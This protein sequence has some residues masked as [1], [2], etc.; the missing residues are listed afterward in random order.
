MSHESSGKSDD[1][2][3][4]S[5]IFDALGERFD[6][7]V[8]APEDRTFVS[9]PATNFLTSYALDLPWF[10]FVWMNPPPFGKRGSKDPWLDKFF[11]HGNG[12][13]LTPDR[14]GS[15]WWQSAFRRA[16]AVL[17]CCGKPKFVRPDGSIGK[18]PGNNVCLWASG[19][20]AVEALLRAEQSGLGVVASPTE[21]RVAS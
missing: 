18:S 14:S 4:P 17:F 6:L 16:D 21:R 3:T 10:G 12:I 13:A 2:F 11:G 20:R 8:A 1:W 15:P 19:K 9:V 5:Y 7:D